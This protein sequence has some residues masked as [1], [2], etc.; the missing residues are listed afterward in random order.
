[1]DNADIAADLQQREMDAAMDRIRADQQRLTR[2][3]LRKCK[4]CGEPIEDYR[5]SWTDCCVSCARD[6][7]RWERTTLFNRWR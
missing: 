7:E 5:R 1:M 4:K 2:N 3:V 6:R